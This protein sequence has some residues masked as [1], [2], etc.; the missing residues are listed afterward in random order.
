[1]DTRI[2]MMTNHSLFSDGLVSCLREY[3]EQ[4]ELQVFDP[5]QPDVISDI[6]K[7]HPL[8]IILEE[9]EEQ[10]L[11]ISSIKQ[12]SAILPNLLIIYLYLNQPDILIIQSERHPA[13]G[14]GE[15]MDIIRQTN[16]QFGQFL[17]KPAPQ[18]Q[19]VQLLTPK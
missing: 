11:N 16:S 19:A 7:F 6:V 14:V 8:V 12:M 18:L 13:N 4:L 9:N 10:Q 15:L 5:S 2:A 17:Q 1:M 3:Q